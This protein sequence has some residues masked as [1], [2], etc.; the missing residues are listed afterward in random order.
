MPGEP[1]NWF[2]VIPGFREAVERENAIRDAAFL[3]IPE[4]IC[5]IEVLP[6]TPRHFLLLDGI[7]SP[8]VVGGLPTAEAIAQFIWVVSPEFRVI[9]GWRDRLAQYRFVKRC[10]KINWV[11][12]VKAIDQYINDAFQDSP[13]AKSGTSNLHDWSWVAALVDQIAS[14]YHWSEVDILS[15]PVKRLFQYSRIVRRRDDPKAIF[16]NPRDRV[17][18]E[19]LRERN[20]KAQTN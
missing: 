13:G 4:T 3:D 7:G 12:A 17:R 2:A 19:W 9:R 18:G 1:I 11:D 10:R 6:M 20:Q 15:I 16:F 14:T 8:F 5:G